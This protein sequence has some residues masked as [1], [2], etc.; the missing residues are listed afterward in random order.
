MVTHTTTTSSSTTTT[1]TTVAPSMRGITSSRKRGVGDGIEEEG[2]GPM[3]LQE[4]ETSRRR[5]KTRSE[6]SGTSYL[7]GTRK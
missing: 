5:C 7:E 3:D 1:T 6:S 4:V 2:E